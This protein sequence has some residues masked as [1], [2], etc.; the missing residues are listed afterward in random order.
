MYQLDDTSYIYA[1]A[2]LPFC[3]R[4]LGVSN[5]KKKTQATFASSK[6][7]DALSPNRS[8]LSL[9][10]L[11]CHARF[12]CLVIALINPKIGTQLETVKRE[13]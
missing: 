4:I 13:V 7:L 1:F 10:K 12:S 8:V 11:C 5:W 6:I 9:L 3:A 2:L